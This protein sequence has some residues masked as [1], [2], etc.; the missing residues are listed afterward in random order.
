MTMLS[1][2]Q[3]AEYMQAAGFRG[4]HVGYMVAIALAESG[5]NTEAVSPV[6]P[7]GTRG[8][9]LIQIETENLQGGNW[10]DPT[11]QAQRGWEMTGHATNYNPWCTACDPMPGLINGK[12]C[13]GYGSGNATRFLSEGL[14]AAATVE[15]AVW[16]GVY[17]KLGSI[18]YGTGVWQHRMNRVMG[19]H[20]LPDRIFG[21]R[22]QQV[23]EAFQKQHNLAPDGVVG[24]ATWAAGFANA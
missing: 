3:I 17:L 16:P 2:V 11:W 4:E 10:Q 5:G 23:T 14:Q 13:G 15:H 12:G 18:G 1:P 22:T 24:P 9:G 6:V 7:D 8:Y 19:S 20:L 21:I